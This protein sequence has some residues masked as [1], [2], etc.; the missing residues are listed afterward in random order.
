M[1]QREISCTGGKGNTT[2]PLRSVDLDPFSISTLPSSYPP[3]ANYFDLTIMHSSFGVKKDQDF[4]KYIP[5]WKIF[6]I[7]WR[8]CPRGASKDEMAEKLKNVKASDI[9]NPD[10]NLISLYPWKKRS[11]I[12][13]EKGSEGQRDWAAG[14]RPRPGSCWSVN[15]W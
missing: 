4:T 12:F 6:S 9:S 8:E 11:D 3:W 7:S 5:L 14:N 15:C 13:G 2:I 10:L 1:I